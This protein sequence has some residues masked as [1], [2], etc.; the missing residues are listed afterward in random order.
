MK[1]N[2][3]ESRMK[4]TE[5]PEEICS[6]SEEILK[7]SNVN[8]LDEFINKVID[9]SEE[10]ES[11]IPVLES[12]SVLLGQFDSE[13]TI[14]SLFN[15][16]YYHF[17][18]SKSFRYLNRILPV[19]TKWFAE[20]PESSININH[21]LSKLMTIPYMK[22]NMIF[23]KFVST[24]IRRSPYDNPK[25]KEFLLKIIY[26]TVPKQFA[27]WAIK[28]V[29]EYFYDKATVSCIVKMLA[30]HL[31]GEPVPIDL[32][33]NIFPRNN[34]NSTQKKTRINTRSR[35]SSSRS[36]KPKKK[37][38][39]DSSDE[40]EDRNSSDEDQS[41]TERY[42]D[43]KKRKNTRNDD[44]EDELT[45]QEIIFQSSSETYR[46][47]KRKNSI[48]LIQRAAQY[49]ADFFRIGGKYGT[50]FTISIIC[51][52]EDK[53]IEIGLHPFHTSRR[54]YLE[55]AK[56]LSKDR[57]DLYIPEKSPKE[58]KL[59]F[60]STP[61]CKIVESN[62]GKIKL[63][64]VE[65]TL[66]NSITDTIIDPI[67]LTLYDDNQSTRAL[68][69]LL[70]TENNETNFFTQDDEP[71]GEQDYLLSIILETLQLFELI[72]YDA[73]SP[74]QKVLHKNYDHPLDFANNMHI[75][76]LALYAYSQASMDSEDFSKVIELA[77]NHS[78]DNL[79]AVIIMKA[80]SRIECRDFV[81]T[82]E[83][84]E[85]G[86]IQNKHKSLRH[87]LL[88]HFNVSSSN[89][90]S[91]ISPSMVNNYDE[92]VSLIPLV[93]EPI[94]RENSKE[95]LACF[96]KCNLSQEVFIPYY[97]KL[98]QYETVNNI[99]QTFISLLQL[100]P[101]NEET[102]KL[103][104]ERISVA[105]TVRNPQNP[106]VH[107]K[108]SRKAAFEFLTTD[109][110]YP[111][112]LNHLILL[113]EVP[114]TSQKLSDDF[115]FKGRNGINNLGSTCYINTLMQSLNTASN[116]VN[117]IL[118]L[119]TEGLSP[120]LS[121]LRDFMGQLRYSRNPSIS[122][123]PLLIATIPNFDPYKQED[124]E[125]FLLTLINRIIDELKDDSKPLKDELELIMEIETYQNGSEEKEGD[126]LIESNIVLPLPIHK[127]TNLFDSF[128]QY[129]DEEIMNDVEI[130]STE[131]KVTAIR[132]QK[133]SKWPNYLII[134][135]QRYHFNDQTKTQTKL[136]HEYGF[137]MEF[138][139]SMP[140]LESISSDSIKDHPINYELSAIL[141]H[142]GDIESGHYFAIVNGDNGDWYICDDNQIEKFDIANI[143]ISSFGSETSD[144]TKDD[145]K[146][147][148][149]LLFYRRVDIEIF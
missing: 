100:I 86:L 51:P 120:Y 149:Y 11:L 127:S 17:I 90:S 134:Q 140:E 2:S 53:E 47:E 28:N 46:D 33:D 1:K 143:P 58:D 24:V 48:Y 36:R 117:R 52:K 54:I 43:N 32:F 131:K 22:I 102:I 128:R 89:S 44:D 16:A 109:Q 97:K 139:T 55:V 75:F 65:N 141:V 42:H 88:C 5:D 93:L 111:I 82:P 123:K 72:G 133:V 20:A 38:S 41:D 125:E 62:I 121:Q 74:L 70:S 19:L 116:V 118:S 67:F 96:K 21:I 37:F 122:I 148:A 68:Y 34:N 9:L 15:K 113:P 108:K 12:F 146:L 25:L 73:L 91:M 56:A 81:F 104:Y 107:C 29:F 94:Y 31:Q 30:F 35:P 64:L 13:D 57:F 14:T 130:K 8:H 63:K 66:N 114:S 4:E 103:T 10:H 87:A 83:L 7:S 126:T 124:T 137:P 85:K 115:T 78:F 77:I 6:L 18:K 142:K 135:L 26:D 110:V 40:D 45:F 3:L 23:V 119:P 98:A 92:I 106:F 147:T 50:L 136:Y 138:S 145:E 27:Y 59:L 49:E 84:I 60:Y 132:K 71:L 129:F 39:D 112:L 80:I 105:P 76:P 69:D 101:K 95:F 144:T 61:I 79:S 99:D